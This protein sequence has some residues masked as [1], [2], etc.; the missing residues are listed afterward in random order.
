ML[1]S[2]KNNISDIKFENVLALLSPPT[3]ISSRCK[4]YYE[5]AENFDVFAHLFQVKKFI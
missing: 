3:I 4:E 1:K 2:D 5:F